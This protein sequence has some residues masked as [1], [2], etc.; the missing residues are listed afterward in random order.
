MNQKT[1]DA[2]QLLQNRL[3]TA[4][5]VLDAYDLGA[6]FGNP[7]YREWDTADLQD[8]RCFVDA[9]YDDGAEVQSIKLDFHVKFDT[10]G[11]VIDAYAHDMKR[12]IVGR[13][14]DT[15]NAQEDRKMPESTPAEGVS[16]P[17]SPEW[18]PEYSRWRHG[19]WHVDN[20]RYPTGGCGCVSNN[21]PDKKWRI[22]CDDRRMNLGEP[23]DY[24]FSTRDT[25]ARA[26][27]EMVQAKYAKLPAWF[28][29]IEDTQL[30]YAAASLIASIDSDRGKPLI[31]QVEDIKRIMCAN[32]E[33]LHKLGER[34]LAETAKM[35][36]VLEVAAAMEKV[37]AARPLTSSEPLWWNDPKINQVLNAG[38][39]AGHLSRISTTQVQWTDSG[40]KALQV[41]RAA[42]R[43][44]AGKC[45]LGR[46][47]G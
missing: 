40:V 33:D 19:G 43:K 42:D 1:N 25:A 27:Y 47:G 29:E 8:L 17:A 45:Y 35:P 6:D 30:Q 5:A 36:D 16:E 10:E 44:N 4:Q 31:E 18:R 39:A 14:G 12:K 20:I 38:V 7:T 32:A 2:G 13:R 23:G 11:A 28:S 24:T 26:E 3:K 46:Q 34:Y 15:S 41:A 22:A 21:Y 37:R 9:H